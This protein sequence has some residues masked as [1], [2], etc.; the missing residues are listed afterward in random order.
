MATCGSYWDELADIA[1]LEGSELWSEEYFGG[2]GTGANN[3]VETGPFANLTLRW[4]REGTV[5]E[6]C[7]T[8]RFSN[9]SLASTSQTNI[10]AC[11]T[12]TNY[13]QAWNCWSG[14]PHSGGHSGV[15]GIMSDATLSPGDPVFYLHHSWLDKLW[16][17]WQKLDLPTRYT[18]M[19][20]P[21]IPGGR[22][23]GGFPGGPQ[24]GTGPEFTDYFGDNGNITTLN[25][26][27][28]MSEIYPNVTIGD[29]MDLNGDV[30][31]SEYINVE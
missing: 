6:S 29:V 27:L 18:D 28:Y 20:G 17:E 24:G 15:G 3:C 21:N 7:L 4:T 25:H 31:C 11:N 19:G 1:D 30:I 12:I 23:G 8:R 22:G 13:T 26:R 2:D 14:G 9:R 16:W 5:D 10:N